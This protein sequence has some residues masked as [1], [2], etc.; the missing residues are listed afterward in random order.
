MDVLGS[1]EGSCESGG[2]EEEKGGG[3]ESCGAHCCRLEMTDGDDGR[4]SAVRLVGR[5][6]GF[7]GWMD[8]LQVGFSDGFIKETSFRARCAISS[9][10][11]IVYVG[12]AIVGTEIEYE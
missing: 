11:R 4:A 2:D 9:D 7:S 5:L 12:G 8:G 10:W 6:V 3:E 1:C